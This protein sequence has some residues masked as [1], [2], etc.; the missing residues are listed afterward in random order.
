MV[1]G[2]FLYSLLWLFVHLSRLQMRLSFMH[3]DPQKFFFKCWVNPSVRDFTNS[4][5][6]W[7]S[8]GRV[9]TCYW[10]KS[11]DSCSAFV[12]FWR[13]STGLNQASRL[14]SL[15]L[16]ER[17]ILLK[18]PPNEEAAPGSSSGLLLLGH[19]IRALFGF[20]ITIPLSKK[21]EWMMLTQKPNKTNVWC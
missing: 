13:T 11:S 4:L 19:G 16:I 7:F 10:L 20:P 3:G 2:K 8:T 9:M 15:W 6:A 1:L 17:R 21:N 5:R 12:L 18:I 14:L